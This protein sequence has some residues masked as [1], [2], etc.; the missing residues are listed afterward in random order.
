MNIRY[1]LIG[2]GIAV[3]SHTVAQAQGGIDPDMMTR[4]QE[5][6]QPTAADRAIHNALNTA[7]IN[8]LATSADNRANFDNEFTYRVPSVGI[9]DQKRSGR[10]WLFTGLN[11]LRSQAIKNNDINKLKLSQAYNFFYDQLEKSNLFLQSIIDT[12]GDDI[13]DRRVQWLF[14]NALSDGG[15]YTGVSDII[16][17]YGVVPD[18]AMPETYSSN[19]TATFS[20]LLGL[21]LKEWG[22]ELR[23]MIAG[24][25][26]TKE[27]AKRKEQMLAETYR[28]LALNYGTPP[29]KFTYTKRDYTGAIESTREYTPLEFYNELMGNDLHSDY[30][31]IMNDPTRP[32]HKMYEIDLYRHTYDGQNWT[33]INLPMDE[34]KQ[35]AIESIKDSTMMYMSCDVGKFHNRTNGTLDINNYDYDALLGTTFGMDKRQRI[36]TGASGSSHAM[37]LV[38]V[39]IDPATGNPTKWLVE[40]SWGDGP[41]NGHIVITDRWLDEYLFRLV[42]N[43]K[44]IPAKPLEI[45]RETPI[46]LPP[47]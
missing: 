6:Y 45:T 27:V 30:I 31:M 41:N 29:A 40:N 22:L 18:Y 15:Q 20:R 33:Y 36:L 3:S 13:N 28:L 4:L 23:D 43:K 32:Y 17:K 5:S 26:K 12:A 7:D 25:A 34:I 14:R 47:G 42:V 46:L 24:K 37:T 19:N 44:Y 11:V 35:M 21:K 9:T 10:C 39:D 1:I 16:T 8:T 38:A 2:M